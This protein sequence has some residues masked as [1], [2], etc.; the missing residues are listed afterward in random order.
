MIQPLRVRFSGGVNLNEDP[1]QVRDDQVVLAKNLLP[2]LGGSLLATRGAMK[3]SRDLVTPQCAFIPLR[4]VF[5]PFGPEIVF[6]FYEPTGNYLAFGSATDGVMGSYLQVSGPGV[7]N[8]PFSLVQRM[9][10]TYLFTGYGNGF[11]VRV[12]PGPSGFA[13]ETFAFNGTGNAGFSPAGAAVIRDRMLYWSG[14]SVV[15]SDRNNPLTIGDFASELREIEVVTSGFGNITHAQEVNTTASGSPVQSVAAVWTADAMYMLLGEPAET[16]SLDDVLGSLQVNKLTVAAGCVSGATVVETPYGTLWAGQDDVWFMPF[17]SLPYRV[18]TNIRPA[19]LNTPVGLRYRWHATYE[20]GVYRLAVDGVGQG[21]TEISGCQDHWLLDMRKG[22][23]QNA[24]SAVW[25]GPHSYAPAGSTDVGPGTWC[26][27]RQPDTQLVFCLQPYTVDVAS[28][29]GIA[30]CTLDATQGRD[31]SVPN[32]PP[33]P[34]QNATEYFVGDIVVPYDATFGVVGAWFVWKVS[35][36][37]GL[38]PNGGGVTGILP[39]FNDGTTISIISSGVQFQA[40]T[41]PLNPGFPGAV[42]VP[43]SAQ[44]GNEIVPE[45]VTKEIVGDPMVDKLYTGAELGYWVSDLGELSYRAITDVDEYTRTVYPSGDNT[46]TSRLNS[47]R[48]QRVWNSRLL[49]PNPVNS[50]YHA[51]SLQLR[52][53]QTTNFVI[54]SSNDIVAVMMVSSVNSASIAVPRGTYADIDTL[55]SAIQTAIGGVFGNLQLDAQGDRFGM[56]SVDSKEWLVAFD[57]TA[58][59]GGVWTQ[60]EC[61]RCARLFSLLGVDTNNQ[62]FYSVASPTFRFTNGGG[63]SN[64]IVGKSSPEATHTFRLEMSA[65]NLLVDQFGRRPT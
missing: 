59:G 62:D 3:W 58:I 15:W 11:R 56:R 10:E 7:R 65:L 61:Q 31:E 28:R 38:G 2:K 53:T 46:S 41:D 8:Q 9:G 17:G 52:L 19:L 27:L 24:D 34:P 13:L 44:S 55:V 54:D 12:D 43:T 37:D 64:W 32:Y 63:N 50:R 21:P 36:V 42:Y 39:Q 45:L 33:N 47:V 14:R 48:G 22:P 51:K 30:V 40:M 16:D 5:S 23:P 49:I 6:A 4:A 1:A 18:G 57:T 20:N 26:F 35:A 60:S 29:R 25:W